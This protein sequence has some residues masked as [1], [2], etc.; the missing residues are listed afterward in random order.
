M[1]TSDFKPLLQQS[2]P[3]LQAAFAIGLMDFGEVAPATR[4]FVFAQLATIKAI[5]L[6]KFMEGQLTNVDVRYFDEPIPESA[7]RI[8][9]SMTLALASIATK[10]EEQDA[11]QTA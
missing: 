2:I 9:G 11:K 10:I 5:T 1:N 4:P 8:L 6:H 7:N 3:E